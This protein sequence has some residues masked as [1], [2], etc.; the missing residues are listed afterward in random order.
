MLLKEMEKGLKTNHSGKA[1]ELEKEMVH[2]PLLTSTLH[3]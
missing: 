3:G 2:L 1:K